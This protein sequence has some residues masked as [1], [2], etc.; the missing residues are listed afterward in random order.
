MIYAFIER[1]RTVWPIA[2]QCQVLKVSASGYRSVISPQH[3]H[4]WP[5]GHRMS[6]RGGSLTNAVAVARP[7]LQDVDV[8]VLGMRR[9]GPWAEYRCEPPACGDADGIDRATQMFIP[10]RFDGQYFATRE[11]E[12]SRRPPPDRTRARRSCPVSAWLRLWPLRPYCAPFIAPRNRT[13]T[14][15]SN[16]DFRILD[17]LRTM[18]LTGNAEPIPA[19][20]RSAIE[21]VPLLALHRPRF[22]SQKAR[23]RGPVWLGS[24]E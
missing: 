8:Q 22:S 3:E 10:I 23:E 18:V 24:R 6:G 1:Y 14:D 16:P 21:C 15:G 13:V 2:R 7:V 20:T 4:T 19:A 12:T 17:R 5:L 11:L 9:I